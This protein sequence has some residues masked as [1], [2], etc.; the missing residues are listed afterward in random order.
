MILNFTSYLLQNNKISASAVLSGGTLKDGALTQSQFS[1]NY[2]DWLKTIF[3]NTTVQDW[4]QQTS[5]S[6]FTYDANNFAININQNGILLPTIANAAG[7]TLDQT[8]L[9]A[10]F[11]DKDTMLVGTGKTAQQRS[12]VY[13]FENSAL[14]TM[15]APKVSGPVTGE[16][17]EDG[18]GVSL[19]ALAKVTDADTPVSALKVNAPAILPPGVSY[20]AQ[21]KS[22]ILDPSHSSFQSLAAGSPTEV[23]VDYSITDDSGYTTSASVIWFV[24]GVND[25]ASISGTP[26]GSVTEDGVQMASGTLTLSD[27]DA[28]E[29]VFQAI[30]AG[31]LTKD[32]G[33]FTFDVS[34]GAW[35]FTVDNSADQSLGSND[36]VHQ[37]LSVTSKDGTAT[38]TITVDVHG[39]NDA[40]SITGT[41]AASV[42]EDGVQKASGTLAVHDVDTGEEVFQSVSSADLVK[43]YGSFTFDANTG[44]WDFTIDNSAAQSLD[45]GKTVQQ[46]LTVFSKDGTASETITV[47]VHGANDAASI[48]GTKSGTVYEDAVGPGEISNVSGT[49]TVSDVDAGENVFQAVPAGSLV[50]DYGAFTFDAATGAWEFTTDNAAAQSLGAGQVVQQTLTVASKDG[51]ASETITVDVV[52]KAEPVKT[53]TKVVIS[54]FETGT[55]TS[56]EWAVKEG[57]LGNDGGATAT[58]AT[59]GGNKVAQIVAT[60]SIIKTVSLTTGDVFQFDWMFDSVQPPVAG[61]G[62]DIAYYI[63]QVGTKHTLAT[64]FGGD[65][66]WATSKFTAAANGT[67]T[68]VIGIEN[69]GTGSYANTHDSKLYVDNVWL[70]D[71]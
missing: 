8:I 60:A 38:E 54:D 59:V 26:T 12:Y 41:D 14:E 17:T 23:K 9:N 1:T 43:A 45:A 21:T 30:A 19:S 48:D 68:F 56:N 18:A 49:L 2:T 64:A 52:G 44:A 50:K 34:T 67:Y 27:V 20:D 42:T 61:Q 47:E 31:D 70:F 10:L 62:N 6:G 15:F 40:A 46:S 24:K 69:V 29:N 65:T 13:G 5:P 36:V 55:L 63:D 53:P 66:P 28:G 57:G 22:F 37:K 11:S 25:A 51:T 7:Q 58:I 16:A 71:I 33:S 39:V 35:K 4:I 3:I 32:Y